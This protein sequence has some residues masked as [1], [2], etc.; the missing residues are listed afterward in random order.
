M[1]EG[2]GVWWEGGGI[3]SSGC[4]PSPSPK[5]SGP[6]NKGRAAKKINVF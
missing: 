3:Q 5:G 4:F 6:E 1:G 2:L